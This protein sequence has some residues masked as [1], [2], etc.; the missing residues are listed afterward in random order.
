M[1]CIFH[2]LTYDVNIDLLQR[3]IYIFW[4]LDEKLI[5]NWN[6]YTKVFKKLL[7]QN[8]EENEITQQFWCLDHKLF[9]VVVIYIMQKN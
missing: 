3:R 9:W 6:V 4:C 5:N 1:I 8:N 2:S 7:A